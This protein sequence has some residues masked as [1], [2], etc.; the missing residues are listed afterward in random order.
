[1]NDIVFQVIM[2][3]L[4]KAV[5]DKVKSGSPVSR[6]LF[7]FAYQYKKSALENGYDTPILNMYVYFSSYSGALIY[8]TCTFGHLGGAV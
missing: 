5:W 4:Y 7:H 1:M 6:G 2:D 8:Y 3:R